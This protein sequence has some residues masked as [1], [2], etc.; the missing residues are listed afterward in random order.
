MSNITGDFVAMIAQ[1]W[2]RFTLPK[3]D[4]DTLAALL[5]PMDDAGE[6]VAEDIRLDGEPSDFDLALEEL[7]A[8]R[9]KS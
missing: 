4:T 3:S 9:N 1:V 5:A 8:P 7:A 6:T 2:H